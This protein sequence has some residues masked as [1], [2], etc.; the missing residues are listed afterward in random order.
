MIFAMLARVDA[1]RKA[2]HIAEPFCVVL[3]RLQVSHH[4]IQSEGVEARII[5]RD[6]IGRL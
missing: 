2:R 3:V 1:R 5:P 6:T 4:G